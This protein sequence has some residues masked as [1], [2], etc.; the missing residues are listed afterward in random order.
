MKLLALFYFALSL[1]GCDIGR[2]TFV[3]RISAD[4]VDSLY[5][6]ATVE[7]GFARFECLRSA[8]GQCYYT[9]F[10]RECAKTPD[11]NGQHDT[12]CLSRPVERFAVANG[13]SRLFPGLRNFRVCVSADGKALGVDCMMPKPIAAR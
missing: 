10:P 1:F 8:S 13:E 4:G 2:S 12:R 11:A 3:D 9:L 5:S 7:A 6:K